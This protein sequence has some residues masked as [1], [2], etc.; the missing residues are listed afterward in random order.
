[1]ELCEVLGGL[2]KVTH[3]GV[4]QVEVTVGRGTPH[5]SVW[6]AAKLQRLTNKLK[7]MGP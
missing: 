5:V 2:L 7:L 3:I 1:M 4:S 6:L